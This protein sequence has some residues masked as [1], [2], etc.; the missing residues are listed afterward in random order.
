MDGHF[1]LRVKLPAEELQLALVDPILPPSPILTL[2]YD[3]KMLKGLLKKRKKR[4]R[5]TQ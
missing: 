2:P 1:H 4:T 3:S 5:G